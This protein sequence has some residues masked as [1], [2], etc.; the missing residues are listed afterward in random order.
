M[1]TGPKRPGVVTFIGVIIYISAFLS[2]VAGLIFLIFNGESTIQA[3]VGQGSDFLVWTGIVDLV[4]AAITFVV[5]RGVMAGANWSRIFVV[6]V[7]A[8]RMAVAVASMVVLEDVFYAVFTLLIGA[9][10][11]WALYGNERAN[12]YFSELEGGAARPRTAP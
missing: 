7:Q 12:E 3:Q 5:A 9:F 1:A 4:I 8:I 10:V 6:V 11:V 2:L